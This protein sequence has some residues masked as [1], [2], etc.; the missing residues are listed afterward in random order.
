MPS[1]TIL[2]PI[3]EEVDVEAQQQNDNL[4]ELE[5]YKQFTA[6]DW[7]ICFKWIFFFVTI[8]ALGCLLLYIVFYSLEKY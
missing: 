1:E 8:L 2:Q 6:D 5:T 7:C 4:L 3:L